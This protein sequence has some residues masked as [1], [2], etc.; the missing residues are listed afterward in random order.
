MLFQRYIIV[1][2]VINGVGLLGWEFAQKSS[3]RFIFDPQDTAA[4]LGGIGAS[5][6]LFHALTPMSPPRDN[7]KL[8]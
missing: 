4:T 6:L 3:S 7:R 8:D 5:V 1:S 2:A